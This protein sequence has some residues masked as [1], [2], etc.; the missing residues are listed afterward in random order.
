[1]YHHYTLCARI[2]EELL[3]TL[4][5][6]AL[7]IY[8]YM[9]VHICVSVHTDDVVVHRNEYSKHTVADFFVVRGCATDDVTQITA[10]Y[11]PVAIY[12]RNYKCHEP[13]I[14]CLRRYTVAIYCY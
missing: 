9:Y 8:I 11:T 7:Q 4:D 6:S 12:N 13:C 5:K 10:S 1:M 2:C 14:S 3:V